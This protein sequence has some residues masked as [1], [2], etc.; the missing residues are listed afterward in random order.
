MAGGLEKKEE[1]NNINI[2]NGKGMTDV[3][4]EIEGIE[5]AD[6]ANEKRPEVCVRCRLL[7]EESRS[8]VTNDGCSIG[9]AMSKSKKVTEGCR[10]GKSERPLE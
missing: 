5:M 10:F 7:G 9:Q 4:G 1:R 6:L 2:R 8:N 3:N